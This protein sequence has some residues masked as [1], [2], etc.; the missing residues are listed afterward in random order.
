MEL[1]DP[2]EGKEIQRGGSLDA[3]YT[4]SW[5]EGTDL[6]QLLSLDRKTHL[7]SHSW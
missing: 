2:T 6:S 4:I 7:K 5:L 1:L 3:G